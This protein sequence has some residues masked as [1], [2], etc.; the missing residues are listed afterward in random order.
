MGA[1]NEH[2]LGS[3]NVGLLARAVIEVITETG[4]KGCWEK[5]AIH[6]AGSDELLLDRHRD[7]S[8]EELL[9]R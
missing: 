7:Y 6:G 3:V 1:T 5:T 4:L 9:S 2:S 8:S